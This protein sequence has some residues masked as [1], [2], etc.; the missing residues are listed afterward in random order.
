MSPALR[1]QAG[2]LVEVGGGLVG[3]EPQV[4]GAD[5]DQLAADPPP[6]QR[7]VGVGA[8]ADHD[9]HVR[10]EVL[11]QEGHPLA[12]VVAVDQVVVVEHQPHLRRCRGQLVEQRGEHEVGR[13]GRGAE[14]LQRRRAD[15]G[16]APWRA[17]TTYVQNDAGSLSDGSSESHATARSSPGV[18]VQPRGEQ[19]RLAEPRRGRHQGQRESARRS[20]SRSRGRATRP[21]RSFGTYSLVAISGRATPSPFPRCTAVSDVCRW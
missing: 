8:G 11:E 12:D 6:S 7:Q 13:H 4:G 18:V 19:R 21:R 17:V 3:G 16:T 15:A 14:E 10:R 20:R 2:G 9:V 1:S 5:L